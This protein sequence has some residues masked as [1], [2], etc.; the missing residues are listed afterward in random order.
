MPL[1]LA[2][3]WIGIMAIGAFVRLS[4][5]D[6]L[7]P[8]MDEGMYL[9]AG[10]NAFEPALD[11]AW[12]NGWKFGY[13]LLAHAAETVAGSWIGAR[14]LNAAIGLATVVIAHAWAR[15]VIFDMH[16]TD[17]R[18]RNEL[19]GLAG[20][21]LLSFA[22]PLVFTS[23][24]ATYDALAFL[25]F[26]LALYFGRRART[27]AE[28]TPESRAIHVFHAASAF[29]L[30]AGVLSKYVVILYL[31]LFVAD[32]LLLSNHRRRWLASALAPLA[33]LTLVFAIF[34][35]AD[36][37][38]GTASTAVDSVK[39]DWRGITGHTASLIGA[40]LLLAVVGLVAAPRGHRREAL[41]LLWGAL[42]LYAF[43]LW[44][45]HVQ[46]L[47][48]LM[49]FS[50]ILLAPLFGIGFLQLVNLAT[51]GVLRRTGKLR[52][53]VTALGLVAL[54][55]LAIQSTLWVQPGWKFGWWHDRGWVVVAETAVHDIVKERYGRPAR[56]W[57]TRPFEDMAMN[58]DLQAGMNLQLDRSDVSSPYVEPSRIPAVA[59][60][61]FKI[62]FEVVLGLIERRELDMYVVLDGDFQQPERDRL[63][64]IGSS[65][66]YVLLGIDDRPSDTPFG[67]SRR[68]S[69][70]R[71]IVKA[72]L[73]GPLLER[74]LVR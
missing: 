8:W 14:Y 26:A 7:G 49:S 71:V 27:V 9:L 58:P 22:M 44:A 50:L 56:I 52:P 15:S 33:V 61:M 74:G 6:Y 68:P 54:V 39:S 13:P 4:R 1:W 5:M 66:A 43:Y 46:A 65:H 3:A 30:F 24:L 19:R 23:R 28:T 48:K 37:M 57:S 21:A 63:D 10:R 73:F 38:V 18:A 16:R 35:G 2:I 40:P 70:A 29:A 47:I 69:R 60:S 42:I 17:S 25:W 32:G 31:P 64:Q 12:L 41:L 36:F 55:P 59:A 11:F 20:L 62:D 34:W 45:G 53:L 67:V 72:E 51:L